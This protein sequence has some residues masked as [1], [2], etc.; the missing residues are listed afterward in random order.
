M[1]DMGFVC[2]T[3]EG[4]NSPTQCPGYPVVR[5][6]PPL[7]LKNPEWVILDPTRSPISQTKTDVDHVEFHRR[8]NPMASWMTI[9]KL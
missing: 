6:P 3:G 4:R 9:S 5:G 7:I 1:V 2:E 8:L